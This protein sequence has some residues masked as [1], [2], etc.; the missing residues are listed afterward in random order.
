M[1][2]HE[3]TKTECSELLRHASLVRLACVHDNQPYIVPMYIAYYERYIYGFTTLGQK[4]EWMRSN[5][6]V[7]VEADEITNND[8]WKSVVVLGRYE[9]LPDKP[10]FETEQELAY[11]LLR[12]RHSNWW[13]PGLVSIPHRD[14]RDPLYYR[15]R[16]EHV[17]GRCA[18]RDAAEISASIPSATKKNRWL[19]SIFHI[20]RD[21][22]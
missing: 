21:R 6:L 5:P 18:K 10:D 13:Q 14:P 4:V 16:I 3:M 20:V 19:S 11:D 8:E 1:L 22:R 15:I 2:I 17:T 7:C 12:E 9:E